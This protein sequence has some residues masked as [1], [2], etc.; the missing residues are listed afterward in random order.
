MLHTMLR[1]YLILMMGVIICFIRISGGSNELA[2]SIVAIIAVV[3]D[4][5]EA[6]GEG[7]IGEGV[8]GAGRH[9]VLGEGARLVGT[10]DR[11]A[12]QGFD[13]G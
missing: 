10:N 9:F 2:V 3:S 13:G 12:S 11:D 5:G 7:G 8:G 6:E 4:A 1:H